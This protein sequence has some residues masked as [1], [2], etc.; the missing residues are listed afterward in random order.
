MNLIDLFI[1]IFILFFCFRGYWSGFVKQVFGI[2]AIIIAVFAT[3]RYMSPASGMLTSFID[4]PD[5]AT[6]VA[7]ILIFII[8]LSVIQ[9]AG[10]MLEKALKLVKINFINRLAGMLFGGL[11][12]A[13]IASA[14]LLLLAGF[15]LPTEETRSESYTYEPIIQVAP[16]T[17]NII[18][19]IYPDTVDFMDT[20]EKSIRENSTLKEL[21]LFENIDL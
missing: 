21:S 20:I 18:A 7:G 1:I 4:N 16:I 12:A 9:L 11:N 17:F 2:A 19:T 8:S 3:F 14:F 5:H 6:I 15:N 10:Y 13:I